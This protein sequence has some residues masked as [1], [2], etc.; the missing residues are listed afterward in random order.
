MI[1]TNAIH[2]C[3]VSRIAKEVKVD[4]A[5]ISYKVTTPFLDSSNDYITI[6]IMISKRGA[7]VLDDGMT[8]SELY[9]KKAVQETLAAWSRH[10]ELPVTQTS[11]EFLFIDVENDSS[12]NLPLDK[13]G[14]AMWKMTTL[15]AMLHSFMYIP[16]EDLG[17]EE[18]ISAQAGEEQ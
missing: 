6:Y 11:D 5:G 13:L 12:G 1:D 17:E 10:E 8:I 14:E 4:G 7:M 15:L 2:D 18:E 3:F 9:H 16:G